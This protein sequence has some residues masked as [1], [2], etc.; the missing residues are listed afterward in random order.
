M[1]TLM[2]K[3]FSSYLYKNSLLNRYIFCVFIYIY[4][5]TQVPCSN[6]SFSVLSVGLLFKIG[7]QTAYYATS[8]LQ[9]VEMLQ[10]RLAKERAAKEK[11]LA[12][13]ASIKKEKEQLEHR[14]KSEEDIIRK[15]A[16]S[17]MQKYIED[18]GKLE[19]ELVDLKLKSDSEKIAAL[20]ERND[21]FSRTT[22]STPNMKANK[23]SVMSQ[24]M[25]GGQDKFAAGRLRQENECVMCLSEEMSVVFLPC[26]HQVVCPE[27]NELH[28]KQGMKDCPSCRTPIQRRV[29]ARFAGQ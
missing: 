17:D 13:A 29:H 16:A 15:K 25:V 5:Y 8:V 1:Y 14:M 12:Q 20:R 2:A 18:I 28:E 7:T 26:A 6:N 23:K 27:C 3:I 4:I 21:G 19:K 10:G 22:K 9:L 11:L 24:T